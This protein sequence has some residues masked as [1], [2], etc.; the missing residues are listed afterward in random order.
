LGKIWRREVTVVVGEVH[1]IG[2]QKENE[3]QDAAA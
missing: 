1:E 2:Q 3:D